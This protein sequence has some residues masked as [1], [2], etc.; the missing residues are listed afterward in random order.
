MD[1]NRVFSTVVKSSTIRLVLIV[2]AAHD[3]NLTQ[4]DIRQAYL[5]AELTEDLYMIVPPGI[6]AFDERGRPLVCKL[7][8]TLYGLKQAGREWG[9]LFSAFL[10][11]WGFV[12]STIDTCLFTYTKGSH[13][14]WIL[15]Y[16][17]DCLILEND[18]ALR[19]RFV[20]DLGK[21]FPVDDRGELEWLLGVAIDRERIKRVLSL[22]QELYIKDLVEKYASHVRAG[23][24]P[25]VMTRLWRRVC[26]SQSTT[27]LHPVPKPPSRWYPRDWCTWRWLEP[28]CGSP[29]CDSQ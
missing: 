24:T 7:R 9:M 21:R 20:A 23:H 11:S 12:R 26:V 25:V 5:Q 1:F 16:V 10:V 28:F 14:L 13:I 4:I 17:D 29:T 18:S 27:A 6:P 8:R 19:S 15:V 2:A 22:S 3:Y